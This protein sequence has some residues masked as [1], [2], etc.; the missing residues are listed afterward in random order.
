MMICLCRKIGCCLVVLRLAVGLVSA[1]AVQWAWRVSCGRLS[2]KLVLLRLAWKADDGGVVRVDPALVSG[3]TG[4]SVAR[5]EA[6][7]SSLERA[8]LIEARRWSD[9]GCWSARL[10][11]GGAL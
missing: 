6:C 10:L 7:L 8:G 11:L 5:V 4:L 3:V 2:D 1:E 9:S